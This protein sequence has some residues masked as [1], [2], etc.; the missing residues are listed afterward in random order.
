MLQKRLSFNPRIHPDEGT[1]AE[2][3]PR[4]PVTVTAKKVR[5]E[6]SAQSAKVNIF[7]VCCSTCEPLSSFQLLCRFSFCS[8]LISAWSLR[9][10]R[11]R[12]YTFVKENMLRYRQHS[13]A[14]RKMGEASRCSSSPQGAGLP[15]RQCSQACKGDWGAT[16]PPF[17]AL[18]GHPVLLPGVGGGAQKTWWCIRTPIWPPGSSSAQP[19]GAVLPVAPCAPQLIGL[20]RPGPSGEGNLRPL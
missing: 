6:A 2:Q 14:C 19:Q 1:A 20:D 10:E 4:E 3:L 8:T 16:A 5:V 18:W 12:K 17:S 9:F 11:W 7:R 15:G 13:N